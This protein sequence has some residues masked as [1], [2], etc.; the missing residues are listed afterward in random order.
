MTVDVD[1]SSCNE[2][3]YCLVQNGKL[4]KCSLIKEN[5]KT[6]MQISSPDAIKHNI[7]SKI[8]IYQPSA[9][10]KYSVKIVIDG[11]F[12]EMFA[13][14]D[15]ALTASTAMNSDSYDAYLYSDSLASF[16][17]IKINRLRSYG[18]CD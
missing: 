3:S 11:Q 10:N 5:N 15:N 9:N 2:A 1:L 14:E 17:N 12:I 6:Y 13:N 8:E 4:Y 16:T 7:N 18:D